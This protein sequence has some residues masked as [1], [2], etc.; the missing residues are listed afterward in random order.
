MT[1]LPT[2]PAL[3]AALVVG[4]SSPAG[5]PFHYP[6]ARSGKGEL[7][8]VNGLPVLLVRGTPDEMGE[9]LGALALKPASGLLQLAEDFRRAQGWD[10][11]YP[12]L[13]RTGGRM[14]RQFPPE[15]RKELEAAA[16]A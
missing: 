5:E 12:L 11:V 7:K 8:V 3:L 14:K 13:L 15:H 9:Q 4:A 10:R 16:R 6:E 1:R 2:M